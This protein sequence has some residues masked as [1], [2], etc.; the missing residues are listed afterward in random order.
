LGFLKKFEN[1]IRFCAN[2]LIRILKVIIS[3]NIIIHQHR[4]HKKDT[5]QAC[6]PPDPSRVNNKLNYMEILSQNSGNYIN[7]EYYITNWDRIYC[8]KYD[9]M[10]MNEKKRSYIFPFS[11]VRSEIDFC[12]RVYSNLIMLYK[13]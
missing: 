10:D 6:L 1:L 8:L 7:S 9:E 5:S 11:V 13:K 2:D 4:G 3:D 12:P